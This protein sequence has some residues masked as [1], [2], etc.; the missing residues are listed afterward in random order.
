VDKPSRQR[1]GIREGWWERI[2]Q[3]DRLVLDK[4]WRL[5][6]PPRH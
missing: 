1:E 6:L 3:A 4:S 2:C 5:V